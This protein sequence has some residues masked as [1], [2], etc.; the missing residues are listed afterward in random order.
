MA[1]ND[2]ASNMQPSPTKKPSRTIF[3]MLVASGLALVIGY[4]PL[5]PAVKHGLSLILQA[6]GLMDGSTVR[7]VTIPPVRVP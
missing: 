4:S 2:T 7:E 6:A 1:S 3:R 5:P